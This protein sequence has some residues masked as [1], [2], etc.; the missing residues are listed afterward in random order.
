MQN[1]RN[2]IV[3]V[4]NTDS[5]I[6]AENYLNVYGLLKKADSSMCKESAKNCLQ[7][8]TAESLR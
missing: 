6:Y 2:I 8:T 3:H 4:V 7:N 1:C 5:Y